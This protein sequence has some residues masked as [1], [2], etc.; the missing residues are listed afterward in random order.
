MNKDVVGSIKK[1]S[2]EM[3]FGRSSQAIHV[4]VIAVKLQDGNITQENLVLKLNPGSTAE[5]EKYDEADKTKGNDGIPGLDT[6]RINDHSR[7]D[8]PTWKPRCPSLNYFKGKEK[9]DTHYH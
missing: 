8:K 3:V 5:D 4:T 1:T 6:A 7:V 9:A 2:Y